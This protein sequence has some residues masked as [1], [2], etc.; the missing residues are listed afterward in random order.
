[1]ASD[2]TFPQNDG[3]EKFI[4]Y[5]GAPQ[6]FALAHDMFLPDVFIQSARTHPRGEWGFAF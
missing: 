1:M 2:K 4:R 5:D 6:E 3:R